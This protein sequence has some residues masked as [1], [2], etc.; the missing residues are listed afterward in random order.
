MSTP[1]DEKRRTP[2]PRRLPR[3]LAVQAKADA[4]AELFQP[5]PIVID[6]DAANTPFDVRLNA[7]FARNGW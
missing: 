4:I 1:A 6:P 2:R 5:V 3:T 7:W